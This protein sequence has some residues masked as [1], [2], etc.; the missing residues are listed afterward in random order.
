MGDFDE[1][2]RGGESRDGLPLVGGPYDGGDLDSDL[3][4]GRLPNVLVIPADGRHAHYV[5]DIDAEGP[6]YR[7]WGF[8]ARTPAEADSRLVRAHA[9]RAR[10]TARALAGE[11]RRV[12]VAARAERGRLAAQ[13][14]DLRREMQEVRR[15]S[16]TARAGVGPVAEAVLAGL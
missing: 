6:L 16:A 9:E 15:W 14:A 4:G 13:R 1:D 3:F 2:A 5:A 7:F 12:A 8:D 11:A 10:E